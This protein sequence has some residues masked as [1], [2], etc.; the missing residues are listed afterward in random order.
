MSEVACLVALR[1]CRPCVVRRSASF[2]GIFVACFCINQ[3]MHPSL[4]PAV[5]QTMGAPNE[6]RQ[7]TRPTTATTAVLTSLEARDTQ[8][9]KERKRGGERSLFEHRLKRAA[10]VPTFAPPP[11]KPPVSFD[12]RRRRRPE[13][14]C[15]L[16]L[17]AAYIGSTGGRAF[18]LPPP[19]SPCPARLSRTKSGEAGETRT[20]DH[21]RT[22]KKKKK[23][24]GERK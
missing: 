20:A 10:T 3:T 17:S 6:C 18:P 11:S 19:R 14:P 8:G 22:P 23:E 12:R 13:P 16:P 4:P 5:H 9:R 24:K 21:I 1:A 2:F 15:G 7:K